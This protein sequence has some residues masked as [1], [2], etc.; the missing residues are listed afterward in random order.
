VSV[1]I[2][3]IEERVNQLVAEGDELLAELE[4]TGWPDTRPE[5]IEASVEHVEPDV[6]AIMGERRVPETRRLPVPFAGK[7]H[8]SYT[9]CLALM[10][11][12]MRH[13]VAEVAPL[14]KTIKPEYMDFPG[15]LMIANDIRDIQHLVASIRIYLRDRLY[16]LQ[17]EV[18]QAYA[19]DQLTEATVLMKAR[20]FRAAGALAGVTLE[21]LE[22]SV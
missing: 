15:Q 11:S 17:L 19:G 18:E 14:L 10:E 13:G 12:N 7:C 22:A 3:K 16:D 6:S 1:I 8:Q 4:T 20:H 9:G 21:T 2:S 5:I